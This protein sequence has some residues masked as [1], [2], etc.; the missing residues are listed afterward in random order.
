MR[1][2]LKN[3]FSEGVVWGITGALL[4]FGA[5]ATACG[6]GKS[7]KSSTTQ[8]TGNTTSSSAVSKARKE[9][10]VLGR[11]PSG[12]PLD[13]LE[14]MEPLIALLEDNLNL[15]VEVRFARD[16]SDFTSQMTRNA[17]DLA[18]CAPFQYITAH[19]KAGYEAVL[20]PVRHG[21]DTYVGIIITADPSIHSLHDLKGKNI[22]FV[23]PGST[24]G[25]L[26]PLG[27]LLS[28]G[29]TLKDIRYDFLNGHDNVVLNVL[30]RSYAAGAVFEGAQKL[31]GKERASAIRILA[32]TEPIYN[33]PVAISPDFAS[34]RA[35]LAK[36]VI[37]YFTQLHRSPDGVEALRTY[38]KNVARFVRASDSDYDSVRKY[39]ATLPA[40]VI[41][42]S[43]I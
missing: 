40:S 39:A 21:S 2:L 19:E 23:D 27:V 17:Y 3:R 36:K 22:A 11:V 31:Y 41:A 29:L 18:F 9:R 35:D 24:S 32:R 13:I 26:F 8:A 6:Q 16:Y 14:R 34:K 5:F 28:N 4:I 30:S 37:D 20:R 1:S 42:E 10:L 25:F 43:G 33:E 38:D 15:D 7:E 12:N